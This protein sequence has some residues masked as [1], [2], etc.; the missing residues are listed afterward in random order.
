MEKQANLDGDVDAGDFR[1]TFGQMPPDAPFYVDDWQ[2]LF[3]GKSKNAVYLMEHRELLP[4]PRDIGQE[5]LVWLVKDVREWWD[6][7]PRVI[8]KLEVTAVTRADAST[9]PTKTKNGKVLG[10]PRMPADGLSGKHFAAG[11]RA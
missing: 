9:A 6:S 2:K 7:R 5:G 4:A 1:V 11:S 3:N 8:R 10:R